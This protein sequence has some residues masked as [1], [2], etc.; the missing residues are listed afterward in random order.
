MGA[1]TQPFRV[2]EPE[3][4]WQT[5]DRSLDAQTEKASEAAQGGA[6]VSFGMSPA[7]GSLPPGVGH[8]GPDVL[9]RTGVQFSLFGQHCTSKGTK[10]AVPLESFSHHISRPL[11]TE[12]PSHLNLS[13]R[14]PVPWS[15]CLSR[16]Q[17]GLPMAPERGPTPLP[18]G[19][20]ESCRPPT[21]GPGWS[22]HAPG[23]GPGRWSAFLPVGPPAP[24]S[25][26]HLQAGPCGLLAPFASPSAFS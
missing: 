1:W 8:R 13:E 10:K 22:P 7:L 9:L 5:P 18:A 25:P 4:P 16:K 11:D 12:R 3:G 15:W 21:P 19:A 20:A 24:S 6:Q 14:S 17:V 26:A 23:C 2:P